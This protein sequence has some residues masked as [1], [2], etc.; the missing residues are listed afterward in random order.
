MGQKAFGTKVKIYK[1]N[2]FVITTKLMTGSHSSRFVA[3]SIVKFAEDDSVELIVIGSV[4]A[5]GG[6]SENKSL[7]TITRNIGEISAHPVLIV[8]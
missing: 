5:G 3:Y 6:M 4:G 2:D 7:G 1:K 8:P